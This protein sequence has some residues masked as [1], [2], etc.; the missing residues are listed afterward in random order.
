MTQLFFLLLHIIF[1][2]GQDFQGVRVKISKGCGR[3]FRQKLTLVFIFFKGCAC[4]LTA[5][6]G[7]A[8]GHHHHQAPPSTTLK[9][10]PSPP[11]STTCHPT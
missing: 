10:H 7:S 8:P 2:L 6:G 9:Y 5:W 1:F 4:P 11:L 3:D